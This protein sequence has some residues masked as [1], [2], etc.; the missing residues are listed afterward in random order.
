MH[1]K[2]QGRTFAEAAAAPALDP[3]LASD[4]QF[5]IARVAEAKASGGYTFGFKN[6][7]Q[8]RSARR[9]MYYIISQIADHDRKVFDEVEFKLKGRMIAIIPKLTLSSIIQESP[10]AST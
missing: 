1:T 2:S 10:D 9:R 4:K 3:A 5:L 7:S 6:S 8:A